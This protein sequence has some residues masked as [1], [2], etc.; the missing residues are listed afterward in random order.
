[1]KS[2]FIILILLPSGLFSQLTPEEKKEKRAKVWA[3][4]LGFSDADQLM[5][6][7]DSTKTHKYYKRRNIVI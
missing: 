1:M 7:V 6:V 4:S 2:I 5:D 3:R